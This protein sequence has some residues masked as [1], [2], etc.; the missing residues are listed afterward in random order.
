MASALDVLLGKLKWEEDDD[1]SEMDED[2]RHAFESL[3]KVNAFSSNLIIVA[4]VCF[5]SGRTQGPHRFY[6]LD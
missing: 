4:N 6:L 5:T 2:E 3:R 1:P